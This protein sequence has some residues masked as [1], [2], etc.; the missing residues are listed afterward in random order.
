M[1]AWH[2]EWQSYFSDCI[3]KTYNNDKQIKSRRTD[4]DLNEN[5]I[6][7]FQNSEMTQKEA[8]ER[9]KDWGINNKKNIWVINGNE[10]IN[11]TVVNKDRQFLEFILEPW[12]F[13]SYIEYDYIYLD[14]NG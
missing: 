1:S 12:K 9:L 5:E 11:V 10:T 14:I 4:V 3:E 2:K 8:N 13:E 7:E 6:I